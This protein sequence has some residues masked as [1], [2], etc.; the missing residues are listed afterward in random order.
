MDS[1]EAEFTHLPTQR[2]RY[3]VFVIY[4]QI[5][6][7]TGTTWSEWWGYEGISGSKFWG[8][9]HP[10]WALCSKGKYQSP[11]DIDPKL[12]LY[13]PNLRPLNFTR[14]R[15]SG[16]FVN[17]GQDLTLTF[18]LDDEDSGVFIDGPLTYRYRLN[19]LIFHFGSADD[20]GSE[21]VIAGT[22]FP[23]EIQFVA[24]NSDLFSSFK[25][26]AVASFGVIVISLLGQTSAA[27]NN[28]YLD[29]LIKDAESIS[30]KGDSKVVSDVYVDGLIPNT[31]QYITYEGSLTTPGCHE[32]VT[33]IV[34][35][36]PVYVTPTQLASLRTVHKEGRGKD[37]RL[38]ENNFRPVMPLNN[39]AI[40]TNILPSES[41]ECRR[42]RT[43]SYEVNERFLT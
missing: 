27:N 24:Y 4:L 35:N 17:T 9:I 6:L 26:A 19:H 29:A 11:I 28:T 16:V 42:K 20:R 25:Q 8:I 37:D 21:H 18:D 7:A 2:V 38:M 13:D 3:L 40:R 39:R 1:S 23:L 33:W 14:K 30:Y 22:A 5:S 41:P 43:F 15:V 31:S 32:V 36:K 34:L 10:E 12:L